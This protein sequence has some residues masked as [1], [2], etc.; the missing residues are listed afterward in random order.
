MDVPE[1]ALASIDRDSVS[2]SLG[3]VPD[4]QRLAVVLMDLVGHMAPEVPNILGCPRNTVLSQ[5]HR[6]R[7]RLASL[8]VGEDLNRDVS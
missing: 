7:Q 3:Q 6:G 1:E 5:V 4:D 8:F 2:R